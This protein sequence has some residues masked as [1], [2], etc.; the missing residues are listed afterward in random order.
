MLDDGL[1]VGVGS[2][3]LSFKGLVRAVGGSPALGLF[4]EM[5]HSRHLNKGTTWRTNDLTDMVYLSC[6]AGYA[7][8]VVCEKHMRD[9][10]QRGLRRTGLPTRVDRHL[11]DAV[12]AIEAALVTSPVPDTPV[13]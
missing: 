8:F 6:A 3:E 11:A 5:L 4:R 7:D 1:D 13:T 12:V 9:P 2:A 10:L